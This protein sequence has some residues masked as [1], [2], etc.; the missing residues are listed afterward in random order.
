MIPNFA[1]QASIAPGQAKDGN[2]VGPPLAAFAKSRQMPRPTSLSSLPITPMTSG[3]HI[4][5]SSIGVV[6]GLT[7]TEGET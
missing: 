4:G 1:M 7:I 6:L 2:H 3:A 5:T